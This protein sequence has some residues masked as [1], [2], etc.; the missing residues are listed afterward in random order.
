MNLNGSI[1]VDANIVASIWSY[2]DTT[3]TQVNTGW[4]CFT[5]LGHVYM[6]PATALTPDFNGQLPMLGPLEFRVQRFPGVA[7]RGGGATRSVLLPP[8]GMAHIFSHT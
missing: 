7:G 6:A 8:S 5:P 1:E 2:S 4:V 3:A